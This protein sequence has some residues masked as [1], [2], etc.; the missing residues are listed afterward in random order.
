MNQNIE[1]SRISGNTTHLILLRHNIYLTPKNLSNLL[2]MQSTKIIFIHFNIFFLS[3][4]IELK[5]YENT[6]TNT[7]KILKKGDL[8]DI[9]NRENSELMTEILLN[10]YTIFFK[11]WLFCT[12]IFYDNFDEA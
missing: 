12:F 7:K 8:K 3:L 5:K 2:Q 10:N 6:Q 9:W 1:H 11:L 4:K